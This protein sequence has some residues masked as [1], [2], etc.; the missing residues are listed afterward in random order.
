MVILNDLVSCFSLM[1]HFA[2]TSRWLHKIHTTVGDKF[3]YLNTNRIF[4]CLV[5]M[6]YPKTFI[7]LFFLMCTFLVVL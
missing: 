5:S 1:I 3:I 2:S 7:Y 6:F 4:K